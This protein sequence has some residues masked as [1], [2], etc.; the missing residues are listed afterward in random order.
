MIYIV[1]GLL[2]SKKTEAG[3]TIGS[4]FNV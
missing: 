2:V 1:S 3:N 4:D